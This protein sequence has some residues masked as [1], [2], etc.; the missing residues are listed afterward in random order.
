MCMRES[1]MYTESAGEIPRKVTE[2]YN[3]QCQSVSECQRCMT[4]KQ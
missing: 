3:G 1:E 2:E 4:R